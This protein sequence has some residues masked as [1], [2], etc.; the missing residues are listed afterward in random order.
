MADKPRRNASQGMGMKISLRELLVVVTFVAIGC[1]AMTYASDGWWQAIAA[2]AFCLIVV[3]AIM[4]CLDRGTRRAFAIGFLIASM[5]Y[6]GGLQMRQRTD[7]TN[8]ELKS[9]GSG[10]VFVSTSLLRAWHSAITVESKEVMTSEGRGGATVRGTRIHTSPA[11][12][13]FMR[14]GHTLVMLLLGYVGGHFARFVYSRRMTTGIH[15]DQS[16]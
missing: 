12:T 3:T 5:I 8:N 6:L 10:T 14:I 7:G 1:A 9:R 11:P 15:S 13:T 16:S 4:S 2:F